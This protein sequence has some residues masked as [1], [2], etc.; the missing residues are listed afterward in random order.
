MP[1][2]AICFSTSTDRLV[3][4]RSLY[5]WFDVIKAFT[6][7]IPVVGSMSVIRDVTTVECRALRLLPLRSQTIDNDKFLCCKNGI[8]SS[9]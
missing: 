9:Q 5:L 8:H 4:I 7:K 2:L 1:V 6:L 3:L